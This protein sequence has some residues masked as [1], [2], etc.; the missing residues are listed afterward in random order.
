MKTIELM[1]NGQKAQFTTKSVTLDGKEYFYANMTQLDHSPVVHSYMFEYDGESK[2]LTYEKKD[3]KIMAAIFNQVN[4]M[5]DLKKAKEAEKPAETAKA[6]EKPAED[7]KPAENAKPAE[8]PAEDVKAAEPVAEA[9]EASESPETTE[10]AETSDEMDEMIKA[11]IALNEERAKKEAEK[12]AKKARKKAIKEAKK[13][14]TPLP[15][16]EK[17]EDGSEGGSDEALTAD[18][19]K[20]ARLKKSLKIFGIILAAVIA[21][22][23]IYYFVFGTS[24]A[25]SDSGPGVT[26]SQQYED[27]DQLIEDLQ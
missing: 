14:G 3:A 22:A 10:A 2:R 20:Q 6:A 27:I 12:A 1:I 7:V 19:E 9:A 26:E 8:T 4:K 11:T 5:I 15:E 13:N 16:E 17:K 24:N 18:P 21:A 23:L 25:P